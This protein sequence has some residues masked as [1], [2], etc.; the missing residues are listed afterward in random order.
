MRVVWCDVLI[1]EITSTVYS[2]L[3]TLKKEMTGNNNNISQSDSFEFE[4]VDEACN[5]LLEK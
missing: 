1:I 4:F 2:V 3:I 5:S